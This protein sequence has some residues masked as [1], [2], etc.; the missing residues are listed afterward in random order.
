MEHQFEGSGVA[1]GKAQGAATPN[2]CQR[3]IL[4]FVQI[5]WEAEGKGYSPP[6]L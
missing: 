2:D 4:W 6:T 3:W 1:K 5:Y